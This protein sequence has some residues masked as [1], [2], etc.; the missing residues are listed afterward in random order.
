M[1]ERLQPPYDVGDG[2]V[3]NCILKAL[4]VVEYRFEKAEWIQHDF[5]GLI[6]QWG[7]RGGATA[8]SAATHNA[9]GVLDVRWALVD[10]D[11]KLRVWLEGGIIMFPRYTGSFA[12]NK[13]GHGVLAGCPHLDP[14]AARQITSYRNG[15]DGLANPSRYPGP[16]VPFRTWQRAQIV[17]ADIVKELAMEPGDIWSYDIDPEGN[18]SAKFFVRGAYDSTLIVGR[19]TQDIDDK[20]DGLITALGGVAATQKS[21]QAQIKALTE[22]NAELKADLADLT[23]AITTQTPPEPVPP[24]EVE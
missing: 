7:Y 5:S 12:T 16:D 15:Y 18:H 19:R 20:L 10:S 9:G 17:Y 24:D 22:S 3:C 4:P 1:A 13:H 14:S 8:A 2:L 21:T 23:A 11:A 6:S